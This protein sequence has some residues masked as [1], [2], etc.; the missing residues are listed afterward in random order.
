MGFVHRRILT[1]VLAVVSHPWITL[2][3]VFVTVAICVTATVKRLTISTDQNNL[4]SSK[5]WFFHDYLDFIHRFPEN[6]AVYIVIEPK[7]PADRPPVLRWTGAADHIT[8]RLRG[9]KEVVDAY[10]RVPLDELGRQA[11]LFEDPK[12][13]PARNLRGCGELG[14]AGEIVLGRKPE[15]GTMVLVRDARRSNGLSRAVAATPTRRINRGFCRAVSGY[16][17]VGSKTVRDPSAPMNVSVGNGV[18]DLPRNRGQLDPSELG[19]YYVPNE[20]DPS[21]HR[22]LR[23]GLSRA[24]MISIR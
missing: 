14:A 7:N 5:P 24:E 21:R 16:G 3:V 2:G 22:I 23:A 18:V 10:C 11:I 15:I 17:F 9:L 13:L 4:F 8:E 1:G 12:E 19:Y 6:E 20:T